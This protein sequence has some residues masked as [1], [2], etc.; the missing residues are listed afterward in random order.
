MDGSWEK[1]YASGGHMAR[2]P[3]SDVVSL[4][5]R[6]RPGHRPT[7]VL[8]LGFGAGANIP[9]LSGP[10][11]EYCGIEASPTVVT[12]VKGRF[13]TIA[14]ALH[15]GDFVEGFPD[16]TFDVIVD[17]ASVTHNTTADIRRALQSVCDHLAP[18]GVFL[19]VDWFADA[20]SSSRSGDALDECTRTNISEGPFAGVGR[21]HFSSRQHLLD[22]ISGA[23]LQVAELEEK[24]LRRHGDQGDELTVATWNFVARRR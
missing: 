16:D 14:S 22:L 18:E 17:R 23:G 20:H 19:G 1:T 5:L 7:R 21:V 11:F 3:W 2:W 13:P 24:T 8:E 4:T 15:Q 12:D 10:G 9:F 6:W